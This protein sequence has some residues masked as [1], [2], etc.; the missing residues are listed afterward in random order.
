ML[1]AK[2]VEK[3]IEEVGMGFMFAQIFN[4]SMKNVGQARKD[5]G[6]RTIYSTF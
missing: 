1:E 5:M 4:K 6:I 2:D 3:C